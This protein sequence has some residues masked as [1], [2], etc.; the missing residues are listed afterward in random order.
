MDGV[1]VPAQDGGC[2]GFSSLHTAALDQ[3]LL[4]VRKNYDQ[5]LIKGTFLQCL[6]L[7]PKR[8]NWYSSRNM[9]SLA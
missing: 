2:V 6:L 9:L 3:M 4:K 7:S 5:M 1:L 8:Q